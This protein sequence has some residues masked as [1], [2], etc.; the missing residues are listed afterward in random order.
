MAE[1]KYS[2]LEH[3]I[4][5]STQTFF[6]KKIPELLCNKILNWYHQMN[7]EIF[8]NKQQTIICECLGKIF[9]NKIIKEK[10]MRT[11]DLQDIDL[12]KYHQNEI[13]SNSNDGTYGTD[14]THKFDYKHPDQ[15]STNNASEYSNNI[16]AV[17][18][19]LYIENIFK[20][21]S[22]ELLINKFILDKNHNYAYVF[23]DTEFRDE[24]NDQYNINSNLIGFSWKYTLQDEIL[25]G[26]C[27]SNIPVINI[28]GMRFYSFRLSTAFYS[29]EFLGK[30]TI[31]I[32][33]LSAQSY[34]SSNNI[35]YHFIFDSLTREN[36]IY[37]DRSLCEF[38]FDPPINHIDSI[39][40]EFKNQRLFPLY[41]IQPVSKI[42]F[43][44]EFIC[45]KESNN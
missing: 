13:Y 17:I 5:K 7:C 29:D 25:N 3:L 18:P 6:Q 21:S 16:N 12:V 34:V 42:N 2:D 37:N 30:I 1:V 43:T 8:K 41:F 38:W 23:L 9:S 20:I 11:A 15:I 45:E 24:L 14:V 26:F 27:N 35:K 32:K 22:S 31:L 19:K 44:I 40:L 4:I 28:V 33:E 10:L 39:S 36:I